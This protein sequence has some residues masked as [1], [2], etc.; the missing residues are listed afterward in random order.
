MSS[1]TVPK[2][3]LRSD[4]GA[5]LSNAEIDAN[6]NTLRS[7]SNSLSAL[8]GVSLNTDGTLK[9][10]T[11]EEADIK[12]RQI[13]AAK[14]KFT[15]L[16]AFDDQGTT[17]AMIISP[18]PEVTAYENKMIFFVRALTGNTGPTTMAVNSNAAVPIKKRGG[19]V[20]E[21]GDI[22]AG[23]V[24][25][26][27]YYDGMF[28]MI[29]G[30][31][32][33]SLATASVID[34]SG[35]LQG[36]LFNATADIDAVAAEVTFAHGFNAHPDTWRV[37]LECSDAG[38]DAGYNLGNAIPVA[39]LTGDGTTFIPPSFSVKVSVDNI[40]VTRN[41]TAVYDAS[42][43]AL[44][45]ATPKWK[46]RVKAMRERSPSLN[47]QPA[48]QVHLGRLDGAISYG[49]Y[50]YG[51]SY[52]TGG[53]TGKIIRMDAQTGAVET[54]GSVAPHGGTAARYGNMSLYRDESGADQVALVESLGVKI[55][56]AQKPTGGWSTPVSISDAT[57]SQVYNYYKL[58][59]CETVTGTLHMWLGP[60]KQ[61]GGGSVGYVGS[62]VIKKVLGDA[63]G[64]IAFTA[65]NFRLATG[66]A[67]YALDNDTIVS[68]TYNPVKNRLYVVGLQ[69]VLMIFE[70][71]VPLSTFCTAGAISY[72]NLTYIK[73]MI[74][75]GTI[76]EGGSVT[77][78]F[79]L[80]TGE[81]R[82]VVAS[83]VEAITRIPW[84][85]P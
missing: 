35:N 61:L 76:T 67:D 83:G 47:M 41:T 65:I 42:G 32:T 51:F 68:V 64:S 46:L 6:W 24:V 25:A 73:S 54:V 17:N 80:G 33:T 52:G 23:Q 14:M 20:L 30:N 77:V 11:V 74:L 66:A 39:D 85:E 70:L 78:E 13:S 31:G 28:Y 2:L 10:N 40:I 45:V 26:L 34:E 7:F 19:L 29:G 50:L 27:E 81:E 18:N 3:V 8:F 38:G 49:Q 53:G 71:A 43:A 4:K 69:G 15:A 56:T 60:Q 72:V 62:Y 79:D 58:L 55:F 5:P 36:V 16:P 12:D 59:A 21:A 22:Q 84:R 48:L 63:S 57:Y 44:D 9:D 1:L 37:M 75:G 82:A